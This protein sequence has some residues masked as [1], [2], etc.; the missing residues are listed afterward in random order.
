YCILIFAIFATHQKMRFAIRRLQRRRDDRAVVEGG[1]FI[2]NQPSWAPALLTLRLAARWIRR[3]DINPVV[4][5]ESLAIVLELTAKLESILG[6]GGGGNKNTGARD[7]HNGAHF[8][9]ELIGSDS[10]NL[11]YIPREH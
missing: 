1:S 11:E 9:T 10:R 6:V 5:L 3:R 4:T 7:G 8:Y 2:S